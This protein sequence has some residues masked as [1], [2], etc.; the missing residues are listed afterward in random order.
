MSGSQP[1]P[2]PRALAARLVGAGV[3]THTPSSSFLFLGDLSRDALAASS[4]PVTTSLEGEETGSSVFFK[5][6]ECP[7]CLL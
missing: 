5:M 6:L 3:F 2:C 4:F 7:T 1:D